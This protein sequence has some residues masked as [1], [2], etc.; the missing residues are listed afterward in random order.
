MDA[1]LVPLLASGLFL[2]CAPQTPLDSVLYTPAY[3]LDAALR[4]PATA[5]TPQP[6]D[7]FLST[8]RPFV[9]IA[10]HRLAFTGP[11]HHSGILFGLPDGRVALLESGPFNGLKVGIVDLNYA[12]H[13]HERRGEKMWIRQRRTPL[14]PEQSAELTH[15]AM[16]QEGKPFAWGRLLLQITP[17]RCRGPVRTEWMGTCNGERSSYFCSELVMET[18]VHVGLLD[19]RETRPSATYPRDLFF[20]RSV[21]PYVNGHLHLAEG[22]Y[23]PARWTSAPGAAVQP[24]AP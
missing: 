23:P 1:L 16:A 13:E 21:N 7:I 6:G 10:G 24:T 17:F 18:C 9:A 12:L 2:G 5:Y 14:T 20:D 8:T 3:E 11:P 15:W 4:A 19:A 22:W